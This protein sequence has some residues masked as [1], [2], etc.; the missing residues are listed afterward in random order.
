MF[1]FNSSSKSFYKDL[2]EFLSKPITEIEFLYEKKRKAR[3]LMLKEYFSQYNNG[4]GERIAN[5]LM[6]NFLNK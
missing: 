4:A 1:V 3:S 5:F 2:L 6:K